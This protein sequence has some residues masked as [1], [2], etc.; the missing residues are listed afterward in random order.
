MLALLAY[1]SA[2]PDGVTLDEAAHDLGTTTTEVVNDA[3]NLADYCSLP[4][5][6][7]GDYIDIEVDISGAYLRLI[8]AQGLDRPL[9]LTADE[10]MALAV[11]ARSLSSI[12]GVAAPEVLESA[13]EILEQAAVPGQDVSVAVGIA[14]ATGPAARPEVMDAITGAISDGRA[15]RIVHLPGARDEASERVVDPV[16]VLRRGAHS[17]LRA[18]CRKAQGMRTFRVDRISDATVLDEPSEPLAVEDTD[19]FQAAPDPSDLPETTVLLAPGR[20][21]QADYLP[22]LDKEFHADGSVRLRVAVS[23]ESWAKRI[24]MAGGGDLRMP[25]RPDIERAAADAARMAISNYASD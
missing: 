17:Y 21:W 25:D 13:I 5:Q 20:N 11:A 6:A 8:N 9:R 16:A 2:R 23:D 10:G 3:K 12:P 14:D 15:L 7:G 1:L 22:H 24:I 4:G 19:D 18:W